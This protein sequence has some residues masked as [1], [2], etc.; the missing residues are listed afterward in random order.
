MWRP[1]A[2]PVNEE[3]STAQARVETVTEP[4]RDIDARTK[5]VAER[6]S[7]TARE[8]AILAGRDSPGLT[9]V[10]LAALPLSVAAVLFA[11]VAQLVTIPLTA[12][13][14]AGMVAGGV[15]LLRSRRLK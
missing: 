5:D 9:K 6:P 11:G 15:M 1:G 12:A 14:L 7:R 10:A 3:T 13:L 8:L 2:R 4:T